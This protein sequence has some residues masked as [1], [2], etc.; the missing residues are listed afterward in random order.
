MFFHPI[1]RP[2]FQT[3]Q[4]LLPAVVREEVTN[5]IVVAMP[6]PGTTS[7]GSR[8]LYVDKQPCCGNLNG[9]NHGEEISCFKKHGYPP[10]WPTSKN[11]GR[12]KGMGNA[13]S[14][15][16]ALISLSTL[17]PR[18]ILTFLVDSVASNHMIKEASSQH[19]NQLM[20][21]LIVCQV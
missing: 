13:S 17:H 10:N 11:R 14:S 9:K 12:G 3:K 6:V 4:H 16:N 5:P 15:S 8:L 2:K 20:Q 18:N 7:W 19:S 21:A 1:R